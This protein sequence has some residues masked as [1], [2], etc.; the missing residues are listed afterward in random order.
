MVEVK[1]ISV[2]MFGLLGDVLIRTPILKGLREL[3][4]NA[5]VSVFV[6]PIGREVL[7]NSTLCDEIIVVQRDKKSRLRYIKNKITSMYSLLKLKPDLLIDLYDGGSSY[8]MVM[9]SNAKYKLGMCSSK[10]ANIYNL[11]CTRET[12]LSDS[13]YKRCIDV[14]SALSEKSFDITPLYSVSDFSNQ[15]IIKYIENKQIDMQT[16]YLLNFGSGGLEKIMEFEK[17]KELV[18]YLYKRYGLTPNIICNPGQEY[19]QESFI[20]KYLSQGDVPYKKLPLFSLDEIG[21][22]ISKSKFIITPDTGLMHLAMAMRTYVYCIFTYTNPCLVD[23]KSEKFVSVYDLFEDDILYKE[24]N[25]DIQI[26]INRAD[27]LLRKI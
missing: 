14:L 2:L 18:V 4:P 17:Y 9:L 24:Q 22:C 16:T 19:L 1:S 21:S 12:L 6:D 13:L 15:K 20:S 25:I 5:R 3:Y 23:I 7:K 10:K 26:L 11:K 8:G 27:E